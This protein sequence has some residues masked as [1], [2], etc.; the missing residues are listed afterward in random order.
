MV[1]Q[2]APFPVDRAISPAVHAS[3]TV[4]GLAG[5]EA[6]A[7]VAAIAYR[8]AVAGLHRCLANI[9]RPSADGGFP[10]TPPMSTPAPNLGFVLQHLSQ[11]NVADR[12]GVIATLPLDRGPGVIALAPDGPAARA[13]IRTGDVLLAIDGVAI[14]RDGDPAAPFS[15]KHARDRADTVSDLLEAAAVR[16]FSLTLWRDGSMLT[17]RVTAAAGCPSRLHLAR[18]TQRNAYA[19]GHH[20]FLT[21]G[22]LALLRNDD[23]LAF[24]IA[25]EMAHNIL[26]HAAVMRSGAVDRGFGRTFGKSG[27]IVRASERAADALGGALMIDAGYDPI[28]G[29]QMLRRVGTDLGIT[30]F[31]AHDSAGARIDAMRALVGSRGAR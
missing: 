5:R 22:L 26:G 16:P 2:A 21:T 4:I 12:A 14:P 24:V 10:A 30:V 15:A 8:L 31:A 6:D 23:E 7:R 20:V 18:S 29:A 19:D 1:S 13:G 9:A 11:F 27:T 3:P 28:A 25:H 17:L